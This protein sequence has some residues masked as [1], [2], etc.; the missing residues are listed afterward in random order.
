[1]ATIFPLVEYPGDTCPQ[2]QVLHYLRSSADKAFFRWQ[3][4]TNHHDWQLSYGMLPH[5]F[6][7]TY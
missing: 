6:E 2:T 4:G 1:M 7:S 5:F 3:R